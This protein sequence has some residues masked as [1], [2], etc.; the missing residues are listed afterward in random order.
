MSGNNTR[1]DTEDDPIG[2]ESV[3]SYMFMY[4]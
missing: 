2:V 4:I 3:L 1:F